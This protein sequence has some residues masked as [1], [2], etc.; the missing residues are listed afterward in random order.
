MLQNCSVDVLRPEPTSNTIDTTLATNL[1]LVQSNANFAPGVV[2]P[3]TQFKS[4]E[5]L[6]KPKSSWV[7][8]AIPKNVAP[9][10][11]LVDYG[12]PTSMDVHIADDKPPQVNI[13][14]AVSCQTFAIDHDPTDK[15]P[16]ELAVD[17]MI[18]TEV[19][20]PA[21]T[22]SKELAMDVKDSINSFVV[23]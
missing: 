8:D 14:H 17:N 21:P 4:G 9:G 1:A 12:A 6:T 16:I 2:P 10:E 15:D 3:S 13:W 7:E 23:L 11:A 19:I 22:F 18:G 5:I 20:C